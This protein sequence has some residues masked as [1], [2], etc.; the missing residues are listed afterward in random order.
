VAQSVTYKK[1]HDPIGDGRPHTVAVDVMGADNGVAEMINGAVFAAQQLPDVLN[2]TLVGRENEIKTCLALHPHVPANISVHHA[3]SIV[4]MDVAATDGARMRDSSI[5]VGIR[6]VKDGKADAFVSPGNTG[7][8]MAT[9]LLNLGRIEGVSRPAI[10]TPFP[11][12]HGTKTIVLDAG[13][14]ADCKPHHLAQFAV[15]GSVYASVVLNA[16]TPKVGLLSIGEERSKGND[17][18]LNAQTLLKDTKINYVGNVEGKDIL[19][20]TV[21]VVVT[22]GFTGNILL[23]FAESIKPYLFQSIQRQVQSNVFSRMGVAL[24]APFLNRMKKRFDYA[25]SGGAPLLGVDGI[26]IICH[27]SSG[28]KAICN[29]V[30]VAHELASK[31]LIVRIHDELVTNHFGQSKNNANKAA[32]Q[33]NRDRVIHAAS[34][35]D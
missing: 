31:G 13:A 21:D 23:K 29:A 8:V 1:G 15:M 25:E 32:G 35:N 28:A 9:S 16:K 26:V 27:G 30:L 4:A 20:G 2:I 11:N 33:D 6:L 14:N 3:E 24:L 22:D 17:L 7:A 34:A 5:S 12:V 18:I 10:T 19:L